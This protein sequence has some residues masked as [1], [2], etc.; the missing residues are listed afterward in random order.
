MTQ[1]VIFVYYQS[2]WSTTIERNGFSTIAESAA[3]LQ[4]YKTVGT[5]ILVSGN[6]TSVNPLLLLDGSRHTSTLQAPDLVNHER[7]KGRNNKN[8][9]FV[10]KGSVG[11][12]QLDVKYEGQ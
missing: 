5:H 2:L 7:Y 1:K 9:T 11:P 4:P 8:D 12:T 6:Q 10:N 3:A